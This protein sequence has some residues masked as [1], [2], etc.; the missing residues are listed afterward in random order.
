[1]VWCQFYRS[2][3]GAR[4]Q[5]K[6]IR[7][8]SPGNKIKYPLQVSRRLCVCSCVYPTLVFCFIAAGLVLKS[9]KEQHQQQQ[10]LVTE[11]GFSLVN[12]LERRRRRIFSF[13]F[14]LV[15]GERQGRYARL[16]LTARNECGRVCVCV[17][18]VSK[19]LSTS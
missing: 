18:G 1:M 5:N 19:D 13:S 16:P 6:N 11:S 8:N 10:Q 2:R 12:R 15:P 14:F 4:E 17:G 7:L 3:F 9:R